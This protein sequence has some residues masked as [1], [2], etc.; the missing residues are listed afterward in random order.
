MNGVF[1]GVIMGNTMG[2]A[3]SIT[4]GATKGLLVVNTMGITSKSAKDNVMD[5]TEGVT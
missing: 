2:V 3:V 4:V 5:S 1:E